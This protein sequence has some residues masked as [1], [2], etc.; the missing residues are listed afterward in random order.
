MKIPL[1]VLITSLV[2]GFELGA[3]V[4]QHIEGLTHV[5]GFGLELAGDIDGEQGF[6]Q[7]GARSFLEPDKHVVGGGYVPFGGWVHGWFPSD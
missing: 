4:P 7:C 5:G 2:F 6:G 3:A 1:A